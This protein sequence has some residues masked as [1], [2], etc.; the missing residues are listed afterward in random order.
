M[1]SVDTPDRINYSEDHQLSRVDIVVLFSRGKFSS[2]SSRTSLKVAPETSTGRSWIRT[3]AVKTQS[4]ATILD[5]EKP[6]VLRKVIAA[7]LVR[8]DH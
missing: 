3:V 4:L 7:P 1:L 5:R 6:N 8:L 2:S